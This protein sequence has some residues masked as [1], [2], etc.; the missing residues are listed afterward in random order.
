[1]RALVLFSLFLLGTSLSSA[2]E[3]WVYLSVNFQ[4]PERTEYAMSIIEKAHA[5]GYDHVLLADS[6]L[7]RI[8][9][10]PK[11]Y[12][13]NVARV[14]EL[15][16]KLGV[17]LVPAV[18]P[19]GYSNSILFHNPNLAEGLPVKDALYVVQNGKAHHVPEVEFPGA[20]T[21]DAKSW[22]FVDDSLRTDGKSMHSPPTDDNARLHRRWKVLPYRQYHVT[23]RIRSSGLRGGEPEIKVLGRSSGR[24]LQWT[25][26]GVK[27]DQ[28]WTRHDVTFNSL[29]EEEVGVYFGVWGGHEGDIEWADIAVSECGAVNILNRPGAPIHIRQEDGKVLQAGVDYTEPHDPL[30]GVKP[31]AGE[32]T[33]WHEAPEITT[34]NLPDGTRLRVS[35]YHPAIINDGQV[36][37]CVEEPETQ[38]LLRTQAQQV[39]ELWGSRSHLMSHDEW[40]V[41][42]WDESCQRSGRS[43]GEIAAAN[44]TFCTDVLRRTVPQGRILVWSDMW[45][46]FHNARDNYYL[47]NG[48]LKESWK[49]LASDV[50]VMNWNFGQRESSLAFFSERGNHQ[51][52]AGFYDQSPERVWE[53]IA[54]ARKIPGVDGFMYTTWKQD[55]SQ[56]EEVAKILQEEGF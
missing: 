51:I 21:G 24:N 3:R 20:E 41:L 1:M 22:N 46:P 10:L 55:Y 45:D 15:A 12:F 29:D 48:S 37:I 19:V 5:L 53:W 49:G 35:Y 44:L 39:S 47:V 56:L 50:V 28:D 17:E 54:A 2:R 42:G 26:L 30:M 8:E 14:K 13:Q 6:K 7:S 34:Q 27:A 18:F 23:V 25:R 16:E 40:R 43:T 4:V 36:C 9:T 33:A 31:F 11:I 32:Y 38:A 52:L